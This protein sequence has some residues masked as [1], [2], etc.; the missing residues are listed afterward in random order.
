MRKKLISLFTAAAL[1]AA[2]AAALPAAAADGDNGSATDITKQITLF[3]DGTSELADGITWTGATQQG[4]DGGQLIAMGYGTMT[5]DNVDLSEI[6]NI[7]VRTARDGTC[8]F[9]LKIDG[10]LV[11]T[12]VLAGRSYSSDS[13]IFDVSAY[14]SDTH[15]VSL[16]IAGISKI[17]FDGMTIGGYTYIPYSKSDDD[18]VITIDD[19]LIYTDHGLSAGQ[20]SGN[21]AADLQTIFDLDSSNLSPQSLE[22]IADVTNLKEIIVNTAT[23]YNQQFDA[24]IGD[25]HIGSLEQQGDSF[26]YSNN[27]TIPINTTLTGEQTIRLDIASQETY[28]NSVTL[29]YSD[30]GDELT[31]TVENIGAETGDDDNTTATGF[32]TT[33]SGTGSFDTIKWDVTSNNTE[34]SFT[35]KGLT[36]VTLENGKCYIGMIVNGLNDNSATATATVSLSETGAGTEE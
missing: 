26:S 9:T 25:N 23:R 8:A 11:D 34:K 2:C 28:I 7:T 24:Y 35:S 21:D 19:G 4:N 3:K 10:A 22:F 32:I 1:S 16:D 17:W 14:D 13:I 5:V 6:N 30:S 31:A 36:K 20:H 18:K 33:V 15:T 29:V 27:Y 12:Q